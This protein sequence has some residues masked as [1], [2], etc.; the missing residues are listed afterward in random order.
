MLTGMGACFVRYYCCKYIVS[1]L[2]F[3]LSNLPQVFSSHPILNRT[4]KEKLPN[5][6]RAMPSSHFVSLSFCWPSAGRWLVFLFFFFPFCFPPHHLQTHPSLPQWTS[7]LQ[8]HQP[9]E[10]ILIKIAPDNRVHFYQCPAKKHGN[11]LEQKKGTVQNFLPLLF[12]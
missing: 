6:Q 4:F 2:I 12:L 5:T 11:G 7:S 10:M 3:T 1:Y 8:L 9:G